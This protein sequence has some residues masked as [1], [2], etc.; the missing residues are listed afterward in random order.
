ML[1]ACSV[2]FAD[3]GLDSAVK[4]AANSVNIEKVAQAVLCAETQNDSHC[5]SQHF[6]IG[7][8]KFSNAI[9]ILTEATYATDLYSS[10]ELSRIVKAIEILTNNE[11]K[12]RSN[13]TLYW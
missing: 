11:S 9:A 13:S 2:T 10:N 5:S 8:T 3:A 12:K 7:V 4:K 1:L 6:G